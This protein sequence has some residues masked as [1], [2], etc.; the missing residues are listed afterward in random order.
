MQGTGG[1]ENSEVRENVWYVV[2]GTGGSEK[3][4]DKFVSDIHIPLVME[5][6]DAREEYLKCVQ[7]DETLV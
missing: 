3:G 7:N 1:S 6:K 2:Q 4:E 5:G